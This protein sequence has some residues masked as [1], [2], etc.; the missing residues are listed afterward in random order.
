M[1]SL[2][3]VGVTAAASILLGAPAPAQPPS[4]LDWR[5]AT[6]CVSPAGH[7]AA[8]AGVSHGATARLATDDLR[9]VVPVHAHVLRS[10][11]QGGIP[12]W[13]IRRQVERVNR[14][15]AGAQSV[16]SAT[17]PFTF[18]VVSFGV[19]VNRNWY[20][21]SEGTIAERNA[22][23]ALHRGGPDHLNLYFAKSPTEVL[24]WATPP[25]AYRYQPFMDGV[26]VQR[27]TLPGGSRGP[28]STGDA[29]V[30]EIGHWLGLLHTFT[31]RCGTR[32][33]LVADTP[34][35]A[36]PSYRCQVRRDTC[37]APGRDPVRNFMGYAHD[38]CMNRFTSGQVS[39]MTGSWL[40]YR[41]GAGA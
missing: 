37:T 16:A 11:T 1:R 30:H 20:R 8:E 32:G 34:A 21:M 24:G 39:R 2:T 31:G 36:R 7:A 40:A 15:Y 27:R 6:R 13:R 26:V 10:A 33:D 5:A 29:A 38:D 18:R 9:F 19:T 22:K 3:V 17:A 28:Y 41:A 12:Q 23:R 25:S 35:Q 14:A 4:A